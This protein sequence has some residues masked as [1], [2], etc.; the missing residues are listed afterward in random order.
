[1]AEDADQLENVEQCEGDAPGGVKLA[2]AGR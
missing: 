2:L 1:M